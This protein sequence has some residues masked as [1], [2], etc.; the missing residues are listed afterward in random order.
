[1]RFN[2]FQLC[3][4]LKMAPESNKGSGER[5][6]ALLAESGAEL[7]P[8]RHFQYILCS[9]SV[10]GSKDSC[11]FVARKGTFSPTGLRP[12]PKYFLI[13]TITMTRPDGVGTCV[14]SASGKVR[15]EKRF[16]LYFGDKVN[17]RST[18]A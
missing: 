5:C 16:T 14:S 15:I 2:F 11:P 4:P 18:T 17:F 10:F 3:L 9:G 6:N 12:P 8:Q 7:R 13:S 1:M